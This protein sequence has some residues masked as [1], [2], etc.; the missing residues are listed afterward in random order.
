MQTLIQRMRAF[1]GLRQ[2]RYG[3]NASAMTILLLALLVMANILAVRFHRRIDVTATQSFSISQQSKQIVAALTQ[4]IEVVGYFGAQDK[5]LQSDVESRLK[6][7]VAASP[8]FSYRFVDP[9]T[10]PVAAKNDNIANYGT[11]VVKYAGRKMQATAS[12]EKAITGAILKVSQESPTTVYVLTGHRERSLDNTDPNGLSQLQVVLSED[13]FNVQ[14]INLTISTTIPLSNSLLLVA[15]PQDAFTQSEFQIMLDYINKGGRMVLMTNPLSITPFDILMQVWGLEWQPDIIIDQ[16]SQV[17]NPLAPAVLEYPY[18]EIT[19]NMTGQASV[20]NSVRSIK[21]IGNPPPQ[22]TR[23][24]F[25]SSSAKS[26]A[27]TKFTDGQVEVQESDA[28]GPLNFGYMLESPT[29]MRVAI[30]GDVDFVTNGYIQNAQANA[31]LF[32]NT[33][34]WATA[35][36]SLIAVPTIAPIDRKVF[37]TNDQSTLIFYSCVIGL[38][39]LFIVTGIAVWWRRR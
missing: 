26:S 20:F 38:P 22:V 27:A 1:L 2:L 37:L 13:N 8:Q 10:D 30:I 14:P 7:Y 21:E 4:P 36:E 39:L 29:K 28:Q 32:R 24:V 6:E 35:Q 16:Q 3:A 23:R 18:T 25:L 11:I 19:R 9:D 34:A 15:D 5:A 31:A 12:D 33:I 17:G